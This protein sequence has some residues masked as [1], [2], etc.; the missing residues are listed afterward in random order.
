VKRTMPEG[1]HRAG[2]S[3][4]ESFLRGHG[5]AFDLIEHARTERATA[6]ARAANLPAEQTAKTVVLRT[7]AGCRLAI[8]PASER[9]DLHKVCDVLELGRQDVRLASEAEMA[10]DFPEYDVGAI[11]PI[12]PRTPAELFDRRLL[13]YSRV[14]CPAGDHQHSILLNPD[15]IVRVSGVRVVDVCEE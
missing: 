14:L 9:L 15:E 8:V 1:G 12:G 6:E 5:V 13:E 10:S 3:E 2:V 4:L 7:P 11:P